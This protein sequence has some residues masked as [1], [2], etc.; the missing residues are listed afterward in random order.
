MILG[1]GISLFLF[2]LCLLSVLGLKMYA[3]HPGLFCFKAIPLFMGDIS[4]NA[5]FEL[6]VVTS[7]IAF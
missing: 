1:V 7:E 4:Q 2:F 3:T 6:G 5:G